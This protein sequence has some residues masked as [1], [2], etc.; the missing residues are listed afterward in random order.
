MPYK[1]KELGKIKNRERYLKNKIEISKKSKEKYV[2]N[3]DKIKEQVRQRYLIKKNEILQKGRQR[4]RRNRG[5]ICETN[6]KWVAN[7]KEK[8]KEIK[9][10]YRL[11]HKDKLKEYN[12]KYHY[13]HKKHY[14]E[15]KKKWKAKNPTKLKNEKLKARFKIDI[16]IFNQF[17][18]KQNNKCGICFN[19]FTNTGPLYPCIDHNH[20]T[21]IVRGILC[22]S[23]NGGI[24]GLN[25][26]P[27]LL[28]KA[29][30]WLK[31]KYNILTV[32][33]KYPIISEIKFYLKTYGLTKD[34]FY[35]MLFKQNNKCGICRKEFKKEV[36]FNPCV[37]HIHETGV[38]RG[39]LCGKCNRALGLL[40]DN[41][42]IIIQAIKW[43]KGEIK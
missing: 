4:Y 3:K 37:D 42:E 38:I 23:C 5:K 19:E 7:N 21:G 2:K 11:T 36:P 15:Y 16:N 39:L 26:N 30:K 27:I 24:G 33:P 14:N 20:I 10:K 8:V 40:K 41:P 35:D 28:F 32:P 29:L 18:V 13:S 9:K 17:I 34:H 6:K 43:L 31:N 22:R 1:D 12:K 25:D